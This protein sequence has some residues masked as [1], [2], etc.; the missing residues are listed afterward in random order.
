MGPGR[1]AA[2][3]ARPYS[4][5]AAGRAAAAAP[6]RGRRPGRPRPSRDHR[7]WVQAAGSR[8][9]RR[10]R[11]SPGQRRSGRGKSLR[12]NSRRRRGSCRAGI[13]RRRRGCS[14]WRRRPGGGRA[15]RPG[16][17]DGCPSRAAEGAWRRG[18]VVTSMAMCESARV[19]AT[20]GRRCASARAKLRAARMRRSLACC[21]AHARRI[22]PAHG[23]YQRQRANDAH[24]RLIAACSLAL[25]SPTARTKASSVHS[26]CRGKHLCRRWKPCGRRGGEEGNGH[27]GRSTHERCRRAWKADPHS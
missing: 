13:A 19:L 15:G 3:P 16:P 12:G 5:V 8:R 21:P 17:A 10:G 18:G 9:R 27:V 26:R 23:E 7:I 22:K 25:S 1:R 24:A 11:S 2:P 14:R 20:V 6:A 4:A